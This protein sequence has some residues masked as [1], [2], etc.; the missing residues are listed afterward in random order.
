MATATY[1]PLANITLGASDS[2]VEFT[3]L[4]SGYKHFEIVVDCLGSS[5]TNA[6][7]R[8]RL[9][10]DTT[11]NDGY[12]MYSNL[13]TSIISGVTYSSEN[14]MNLT[15]FAPFNSSTRLASRMKIMFSQAVSGNRGVIT[16]AESGN[17]SATELFIGHGEN[18]VITS[19]QLFP[20]TNSFGALSTFAIYGI[21]G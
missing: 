10:N 6:F 3:S 7:L 12:L 8:M 20:S 14:E 18:R 17:A 5:A 13:V 16:I 2:L 11:Q 15:N 21:D 4:P 19:V 1:I 9:N